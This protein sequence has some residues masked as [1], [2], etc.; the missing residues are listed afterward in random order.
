LSQANPETNRGI[1]YDGVNTSGVTGSGGIFQVVLQGTQGFGDAFWSSAHTWSDIF[2]TNGTTPVTSDLASVFSSFS[3]A[4]G[5]GAL[6][7]PSAIGSFTLTGSSLSWSL[8]P[9]PSSALARLL[10]GAGLL[11]RRRSSATAAL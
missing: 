8:V 6:A 3:Y 4:N 1:A 7:N 11:R 10:L 9:E 5:G 2:T